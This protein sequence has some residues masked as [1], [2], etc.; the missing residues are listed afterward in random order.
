MDREEHAI[1]LLRQREEKTPDTKQEGQEAP[2]QDFPCIVRELQ[3]HQEELAVQN[4]ELRQAQIE[5]EQSRIRLADLYDFAPVGYLTLD[6]KGFVV[7]ANL[8]AASLLGTER[9]L[10]LKAPFLMFMMAESRDIFRSHLHEVL[11]TGTEQTC[12]LKMKKG[13]GKW[14]YASL[15]STVERDTGEKFSRCRSILTDGTRFMKLKKSIAHLSSFPQLDP[16]PIVEFDFAG[17]VYYVNPAARRLFPD[18]AGGSVV[19]H[20]LFV[21]W[22]SIQAAFEKEG[23]DSF[24]REVH[25]GEAWYQR[26][27]SYYRE[28]KHL[29]VYGYEITVRKQME[30]ELRRSRDELEG[31]VQERTE[32]LEKSQQRLQHLTS[33]LLLAQ[34]RERKRI[35]HELHDSFAGDLAAIKF[36]LERRLNSEKQGSSAEPIKIEEI[37]AHLQRV[38]EE[39]RRIMNNLHPTILDDLGILPTIRWYCREFQCTYSAIRVEQKIDVLEGNVPKSLNLAIFR[40]LQEALNNVVKH[41]KADLIR[42]CL[43]AENGSVQLRI[44]DNGQGF[45]L[46]EINSLENRPRGLGLGSMKERVDLSDGEFSIESHPGRGTAIQARWPQIAKS[47]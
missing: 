31:R 43:T 9:Y 45:D 39:I 7:E 25:I 37:I 34:E 16:N 42:I 14:F 1:K 20:P 6:A 19:G 27:F 28:D 13:D 36:N 30:E 4:E 5:V 17:N 38:I 35:A 11:A 24:S 29:R 40:V 21:D 10:L 3:D 46:A 23:V 8:K 12:D 32:E 33:Q 47:V 44:E 2:D 18:L 22:P 41:S 15:V 26:I